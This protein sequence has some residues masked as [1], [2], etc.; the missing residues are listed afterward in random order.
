MR[1]TVIA[2][3]LA[4]V[5]ARADVPRLVGHEGRLLRSDGSPERGSVQL[6]FAFYTAGTGGTLVWAETQSITLSATGYYSALLGKVVPLP[7][8][9]QPVWL[10]VTVVGEAEMTPRAQMASALYALEVGQARSVYT[11]WGASG[12]GNGATT[13]LDGWAF[14]AHYTAYAGE[15]ICLRKNV[16]PGPPRSYEG[17][18]VYGISVQGGAVHLGNIADGANLACSICSVSRPAC[19]LQLSDHACPA[20]FSAMYQ[21]YLY[22]NHY[23]HP[24]HTNR[25]CLDYQTFDGSMK[26]AV[27]GDAGGYIYPASTSGTAGRG[28]PGLAYIKCAMCC[29][30]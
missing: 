19:Y 30:D 4:G 24:T 21:G 13:L 11:Q 9:R 7:T 3:L 15:V 10:G 16:A 1:A 28:I 2:I 8:I 17:N 27:V 29:A 26:A 25:L 22:G 18:I 12:C 5:A 23:S 6:T 14:G 20:G